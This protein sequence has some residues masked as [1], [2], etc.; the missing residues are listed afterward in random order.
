MYSAYDTHH[1]LEAEK[2]DQKCNCFNTFHVLELIT[3]VPTGE[4]NINPRAKKAILNQNDKKIHQNDDT[5][6]SPNS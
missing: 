1:K 4:K 6:S 2:F 5:G 3:T